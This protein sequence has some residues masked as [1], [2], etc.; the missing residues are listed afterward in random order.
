MKF[1]NLALYLGRL[2]PFSKTQ[3]LYVETL[4][5]RNFHFSSMVFRF[6]FNYKKAFNYRILYFQKWS[7]FGVE[8]WDSFLAKLMTKCCKSCAKTSFM[9]NNYIC[10]TVFAK[11]FRKSNTSLIIIIINWKRFQNNCFY[12]N[13]EHRTT[14]LKKAFEIGVMGNTNVINNICEAFS[15]INAQLGFWSLWPLTDWHEFNCLTES[16][17]DCKIHTLNDNLYWHIPVSGWPTLTTIIIYF[18]D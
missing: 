3:L 18:N 9:V 1:F 15:L 11:A 10:K 8:S 4:P 16:N 6:G 7:H 13:A 14:I 12:W 17:I 5:L 2:A